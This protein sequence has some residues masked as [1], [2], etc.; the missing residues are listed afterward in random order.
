MIGPVR[1]K[2]GSLGTIKR[3]SFRPQR[4]NRDPNPFVLFCF[5][6]YVGESPAAMQHGCS[7]RQLSSSLLFF[8]SVAL[9]CA[10][11]VKAQRH[12][13]SFIYGVT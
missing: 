13:W 9:A 10:F 8:L 7:P 2:Y 3:E 12:I 4:G 1:V 6:Y 5:H 11:N